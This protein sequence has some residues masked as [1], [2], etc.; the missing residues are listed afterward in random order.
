[1]DY[2]QLNIRTLRFLLFLSLW[3][4]STL[5]PENDFFEKVKMTGAIALKKFLSYKKQVSLCLWSLKE[6]P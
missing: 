4:S 5:N 1:L 6:A 2:L 3:A